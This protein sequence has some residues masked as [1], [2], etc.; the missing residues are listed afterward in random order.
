MDKE[1]FTYGIHKK[2]RRYYNHSS[3]TK[4]TKEN[5]EWEVLPFDRTEKRFLESSN[6]FKLY[7]ETDPEQINDILR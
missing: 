4:W 5:G 7:W 2:S 3:G 6:I 1:V